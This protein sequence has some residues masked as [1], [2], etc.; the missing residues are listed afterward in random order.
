MKLGSGYPK[1]QHR[2]HLSP[3]SSLSHESFAAPLMSPA[4]S[5]FMEMAV[6]CAQ[7]TLCSIKQIIATTKA[8]HKNYLQPNR[9]DNVDVTD[10]GE[11]G[12]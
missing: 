4:F 10:G 7:W 6:H 3:F 8:K 2:S 12:A 9:R 5:L 1:A 11:K